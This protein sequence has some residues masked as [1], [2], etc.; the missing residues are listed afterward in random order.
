MRISPSIDFPVGSVIKN[1]PASAGDARNAG[2]TPVLGR[3]PGGGNGN[4]LH[5]LAWR[6]PRTEE[7]GGLQPLGQDVTE[8]LS[9][10]AHTQPQH[11]QKN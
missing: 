9:T 11:T 4:P 8:Q 5:I 6:I 1:L 10:N 2:S 3:S 7:P